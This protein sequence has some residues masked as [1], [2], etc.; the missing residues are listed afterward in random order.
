MIASETELNMWRQVLFT[1]L[2]AG[3]ESS[4]WCTLAIW[5]GDYSVLYSL[6]W[7]FFLID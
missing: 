3:Q 6:F 7:S 4:V 5:H 2:L 1:I